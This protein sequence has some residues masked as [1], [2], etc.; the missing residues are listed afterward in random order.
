MGLLTILEAI[1]SRILVSTG[2]LYLRVKSLLVAV[3]QTDLLMLDRMTAQFLRYADMAIPP[4]CTRNQKMQSLR[5]HT[6]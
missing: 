5:V 6:S 2:T 1:G 4:M 3:I